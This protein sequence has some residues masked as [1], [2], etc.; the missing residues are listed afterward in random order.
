MLRYSAAAAV[1][2][3]MAAA[4]A[5]RTTVRMQFHEDLQQWKSGFTDYVG[6]L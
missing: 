5:I 3:A 4:N 6:A 2:P 1:A